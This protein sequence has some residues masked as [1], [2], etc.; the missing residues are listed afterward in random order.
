MGLNEYFEYSLGGAKRNGREDG[1]RN[2]PG[3]DQKEHSAYERQL[4]MK[5]SKEIRSIAEEWEK[6]DRNLKGNYVSA[7]KR[8]IDAKEK[9]K[10]EKDEAEK[11]LTEYR[12]LINQINNT[13]DGHHL[14]KW[15]YLVFM[16]LIGLVEIPLT[17][18]VFEIFG[19][20]RIMTYVFALVLCISVPATAHFMG[21]MIKEKFNPKNIVLLFINL[22]ALISALGAVSWL[23]EKFFESGESQELLGV[24]MDPQSVTFVFFVIQFLIFAS[25]TTASYLA[26]DSNPE[27]LMFKRSKKTGK[28]DLDKETREADEAEKE[29]ETAAKRLVTTDAERTKRFSEYQNRAEGKIEHCKM[30]IEVYRGANVRVRGD[31]EIT[32]FSTYPEL[33]LPSCLNT[34]DLEC[35]YAVPE[36]SP[37]LCPFCGESNSGTS[38]TCKKCGNNL[39]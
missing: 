17:A 30:V 9:A 31:A 21:V 18:K 34:L 14:G 22:I 32:A 38:A 13:A 24:H 28:E 19:D 35:G 20:N 4:A 23:R 11:A 5:A 10:K 16:L 8:F 37:V 1:S 27:H 15:P 36:A 7:L 6:E 3:K 39:H 33:N 25:A 12:H 29:F 2:I 26:H